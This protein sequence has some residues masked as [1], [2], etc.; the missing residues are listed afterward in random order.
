MGKI[1]LPRFTLSPLFINVIVL[2]GSL[3]SG[4]FIYHIYQHYP[5]LLP[6]AG[7]G[8]GKGAAYWGPGNC[9]HLNTLLTAIESAPLTGHLLDHYDVH[10]RHGK[11]PR[12]LCND[13]YGA[14]IIPIQPTL[15][16]L[17]LSALRNV[18]PYQ[19][20]L[21][22][23]ARDVQHVSMLHK[24][25]PHIPIIAVVYGQGHRGLVHQLHEHGASKVCFVAFDTDKPFAFPLQRKDT[26]R[27]I[28]ALDAVLFAA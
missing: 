5:M 17:H 3:R 9:A 13:Y 7:V 25:N 14:V 19:L 24:K 8:N 1:A 11:I 27:V 15:E 6:N 20:R 4:T 23:F 12:L 22:L 2:R 10:A 21:A 26:R 16:G 28:R 18:T